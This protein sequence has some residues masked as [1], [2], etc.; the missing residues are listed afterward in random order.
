MTLIH[1]EFNFSKNEIIFIS[2]FWDFSMRFLEIKIIEKLCV[3]KKIN[4]KI[5]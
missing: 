2:Y 4:L 3:D 1:Q 5:K